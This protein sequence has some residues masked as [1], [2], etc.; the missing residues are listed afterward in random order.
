MQQPI[1]N[2]RGHFA[3]LWVPF[4]ATLIPTTVT[5]QRKSYAR[6]KEALKKAHVIEELKALT[7][8]GSYA[9]VARSLD[10][11]VRRWKGVKNHMP[12]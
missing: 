11:V 8:S 9:S 7:R 10:G 12:D 5:D 1:K 2:A 6:Q 4:G 3:S